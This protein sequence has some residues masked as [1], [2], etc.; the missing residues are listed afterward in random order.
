MEW[1]GQFN[2]RLVFRCHV[3]SSNIR[4]LGRSPLGTSK[5]QHRDYHT[6]RTS[7]IGNRVYYIITS[8][9]NCLLVSTT[10]PTPLVC[11][12]LN[13]KTTLQ[14]WTGAFLLPSAPP[15]RLIITL[16]KINLL[17]STLSFYFFLKIN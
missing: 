8:W 11:H 3:T 2:T 16:L 15:Q 4:S 9:C 5:G 7:V 14:R 13:R 6:L 12:L 10:S 17:I 1:Y